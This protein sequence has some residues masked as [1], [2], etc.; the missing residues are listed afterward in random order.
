MKLP[1]SIP[2]VVALFGVVVGVAGRKK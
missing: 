1:A 2:A